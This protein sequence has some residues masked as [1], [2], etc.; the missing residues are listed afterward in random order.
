MLLCM[1][2]LELSLLHIVLALAACILS[3]VCIK[4]ERR[5]EKR[6]RERREKRRRR[7][8]GKGSR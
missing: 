6:G 1:T 5:E 3:L 4:H 2:Y 7:K 8:R